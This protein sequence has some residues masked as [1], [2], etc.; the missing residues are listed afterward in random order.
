MSS[1][2]RRKLKVFSL[3]VAAMVCACTAGVSQTQ[4][5][6]IHLHVVK[7]GIIIGGSGTLTYRGRA[8]RLRLG[9]IGSDISGAAT[10]DLVGAA[11]NL[12]SPGDIAGTYDAASTDVASAGDGH[13]ATLRNDKG[14]VLRLQV[15][16][17]G[18]KMSRGLAGMTIALRKST[19][20]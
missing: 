2:K 8:Y 18:F 17:A 9:G 19:S 3:T 11:S 1:L 14:V 16:E 4:S 12:G 6:K 7:E 10:V 15:V 13:V 20:R 5:V